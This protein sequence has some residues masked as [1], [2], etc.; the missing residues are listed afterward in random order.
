M[1]LTRARLDLYRFLDMLRDAATRFPP[2]ISSSALSLHPAAPAQ[3]QQQD[4]Q[5]YNFSVGNISLSVGQPNVDLNSIASSSALHRA[6]NTI[7]AGVDG[8]ATLARN[9]F[10]KF[11]GA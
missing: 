8:A 6:G 4:E 10:S 7:E 11:R 5:R 1:Q 2:S 3:Q 9:L